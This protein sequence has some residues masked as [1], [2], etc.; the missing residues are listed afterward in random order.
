[1]KQNIERVITCLLV[2][3]KKHKTLKLYFNHKNVTKGAMIGMPTMFREQA[4]L[5]SDLSAIMLRVVIF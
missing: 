5:A 1:M 3:A 2:Y 4:E